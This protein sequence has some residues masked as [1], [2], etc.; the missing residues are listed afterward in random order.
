MTRSMFVFDSPAVRARHVSR[1][2]SR[3]EPQ[4]PDLSTDSPDVDPGRSPPPRGLPHKSA[5]WTAVGRPDLLRGSTN[6]RGEFIVSAII[7][8]D[9]Y[10]Y[11]FY[12][13]HRRVGLGGFRPR[14]P[15]WTGSGGSHGSSLAGE[16]SANFRQFIDGKRPASHS[17][18]RMI[19][20]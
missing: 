11:I 17:G 19:D 1:R 8:I 20:C 7:N 15:G 5:I 6:K 4:R 13:D 18:R 2:Y 3:L 10:V 12:I 14:Y 16:P 9:F